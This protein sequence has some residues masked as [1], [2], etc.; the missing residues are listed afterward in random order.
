[1]QG[2]RKGTRLR[3]I[4]HVEG[5]DDRM[6]EIGTDSAL[7][8]AQLNLACGVLHRPSNRWVCNVKLDRPL[9]RKASTTRLRVPR[10]GASGPCD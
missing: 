4:V 10:R 5:V 7:L 6:E 3:R 9:A 8:V 2:K 1:M